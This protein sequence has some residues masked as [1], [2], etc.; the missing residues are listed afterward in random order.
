MFLLFLVSLRVSGRD[1]G[2][3]VRRRSLPLDDS[4]PHHCDEPLERC[5]FLVLRTSR[6]RW[7]LVIVEK[8]PCVCPLAPCP[9]DLWRSVG[10][11]GSRERERREDGTEGVKEG[12]SVGAGDVELLEKRSLLQYCFI[13]FGVSRCPFRHERS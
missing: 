10:G 1:L 11:G 7:L 8:C 13:F 12:G 5:A 6:L 3:T 2:G 4:R 9:Q